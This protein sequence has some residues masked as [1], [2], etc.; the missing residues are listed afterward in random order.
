MHLF[1]PDVLFESGKGTAQKRV[2]DLHWCIV[3]TRSP[4]M[5]SLWK[6]TVTGCALLWLEMKLEVGTPGKARRWFFTKKH[7]A[8]LWASQQCLALG[9]TISSWNSDAGAL[10]LSEL[11]PLHRVHLALILPPALGFFQ[12]VFEAST[13]HQAADLW[14]G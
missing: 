6:G 13:T 14:L 7:S 12:G 11:L 4:E 5:C 2:H 10:G 1:S 3:R 8:V 9:G